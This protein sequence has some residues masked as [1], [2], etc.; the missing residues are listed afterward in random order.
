MGRWMDRW[1]DRCE[2]VRIER[3]SGWTWTQRRRYV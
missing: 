1:M 2:E 3:I